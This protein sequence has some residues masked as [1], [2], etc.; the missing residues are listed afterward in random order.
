PHKP[1]VNLLRR[2]AE[3]GG[4]KLRDPSQPIV[5]PFLHDRQMTFQPRDLWEALLKLAIILFVFDVGIRRIQIDRDEWLRATQTLRRWLFFWH[6]PPRPA[7][8]EESLAA[9]LARR[10]AVRARQTAPTLEP[11]P[12][13]FKPEGAPSVPLPGGEPEPLAPER[14][15]EVTRGPAGPEGEP[16]PSTTS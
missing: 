3:S 11:R 6:S 8:A 5:N 2:I 14:S 7:E 4:G 12:E 15:V 10:E 16:A 9:L 1:N 13:L